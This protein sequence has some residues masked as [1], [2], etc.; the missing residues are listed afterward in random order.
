MAFRVVDAV[1]RAERSALTASA[2]P[3]HVTVCDINPH[4]LQVLFPLK[5]PRNSYMN[6]SRPKRT[7]C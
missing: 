5:L 4:M 6:L 1:R 3:A 7:A 2:T